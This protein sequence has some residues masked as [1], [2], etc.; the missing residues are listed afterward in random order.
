MIHTTT[1]KIETIAASDFQE[2]MRCADDWYKTHGDIDAVYMRSLIAVMTE[3]SLR[4]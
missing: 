4:S 2:I 1:G 3:A